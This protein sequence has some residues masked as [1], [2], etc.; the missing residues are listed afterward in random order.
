M[1]KKLVDKVTALTTVCH[2][3]LS[4][5]ELKRI[6]YAGID[7]LCAKS[8]VLEESRVEEKKRRSL[9]AF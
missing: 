8:A 2:S 4:S 7:M 3:T 9:F 5:E 6:R 1:A